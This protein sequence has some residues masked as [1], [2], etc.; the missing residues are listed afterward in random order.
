M[1]KKIL[2]VLFILLVAGLVWNFYTKKATNPVSASLDEPQQEGSVLYK[3]AVK[4]QGL[5]KSYIQADSLCD[6]WNENVRTSSLDELISSLSETKINIPTNCFADLGLSELLDSL[7]VVCAAHFDEQK[8][9]SKLFHY[10]ALMIRLATNDKVPRELETDVLIQRFFGLL[11]SQ[12]LKTAEGAEE[13]RSI[14]KELRERLPKSTAP[15]KMEIAG[16]FIDPNID[17]QRADLYKVLE[18]ARLRDPDNWVLFEM[19]LIQRSRDMSLPAFANY[20]ENL[21]RV[22]P[23][24]PILVYHMGCVNWRKQNRSAAAQF[25]SA[26]SQINP[27][28]LRFSTTYQRSAVAKFGEEICKFAISFKEMDF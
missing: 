14:A 20:L 13:I 1:N 12:T 21:Y 9:R 22:N 2:L 25:F 24:N 4:Y 6:K 7:K 17:Q 8:C 15:D 19:E 10:R 26:A 11:S 28:E 16:Y 18:N 3:Q 27:T 5:P 23:Q